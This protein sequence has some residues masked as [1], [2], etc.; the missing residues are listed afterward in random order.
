M[1]ANIRWTRRRLSETACGLANET[2]VP[3]V[4]HE[5]LEIEPKPKQWVKQ[6]VIMANI[7]VQ[8]GEFDNPGCRS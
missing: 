4:G 5:F 8:G 3:D 7:V 2:F 1:A 6:R